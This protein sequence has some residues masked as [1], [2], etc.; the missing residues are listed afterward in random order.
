M[1]I[2][3][4]FVSNS[5][6]SSFVIKKELLTKLQLYAIRN[7]MKVAEEMIEGFFVRDQD[8]WTI[9]ETDKIIRGYTSM[10]NFDMYELFD[11]LLIP[12]RFINEDNYNTW[13]GD[14]I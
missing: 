11:E 13:D 9:T 8:A 12:R 10:D 4:G 2:R 1:K 14:L 3:H 5:S 7:H 6:S